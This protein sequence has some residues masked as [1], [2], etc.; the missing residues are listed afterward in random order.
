MKAYKLI[1]NLGGWLVFLIAAVVYIITA[2]PTA[3]FWDCGEYIAT[4]YKLQVGH[5]PGAPTFQL[6]GRFFSMFAFGN[7]ENV[8]FMVNML[9]AISSALTITFLFWTITLLGKKFIIK[10]INEISLYDKIC[11]FGAGAVGALAYTFT[12]SFWFSAVEG[13]VYALSSLVTAITFWAALKWDENSDS[14][15]ANRWMLFIAYIVGL[16]IGIHLLNLLALPAIVYLVYFKKYKFSW[17]G[18]V[19]AGMLGLIMLGLILYIIIPGIVILA[20]RIEIFFVNSL[21]MPFNSG[22]IFYI[23]LLIGAL[24]WGMHYTMKK[25]K[26]IANL[27][28]KSIVLLLIGYSTYFMLIIRSNAETPID[29]N[30]PS[31]AVNLLAY[32]QREQYGDTPLFHGPYYSAPLSRSEQWGDRNPVYAKDEE[33]KKYVIIDERKGVKPVY[34][35]EFST[36]FPRM[37]SGNE[38]HHISGYENW[39]KIKGTMIPYNNGFQTEMIKKPT[40]TENLRFFFSYQVGHMYMRY[41]MW[42]FAGRQNDIQGHGNLIDG[43]WISGINFIDNRLGPQELFPENMKQNKGRNRYYMLPLLLGLAGLA[44]HMK[45]RPKDAF[46][47]MVLF[48]MTGLAIVVYL[49]QTPYQPRERDYA[50]AASFYAFAIWI[51]IGV[52][53]LNYVLRRYLKQGVASI[54]IAIFVSSL[55]APIILAAE[56]W[57]D[58]DRSNRYT[59]REIAKNYLD[60]CEPNAIL[61]TNGDNDTFPLWYVQEVEGYRTDVRVVNLSLLNTDWY[62]NSMKR[63]AY[64]GEPVPF[65]LQEHQYQSGSYDVVYLVE[66]DETAEPVVINDLFTLIH[67]EP[68]RLKIKNQGREFDYFPT[69]NFRLPVDSARVV[70]LGIVSPENAHLIVDNIDW[71]INRGAIYKNGIMLLDLLAHN[72]WERPIYFAITTGDD[73]YFGLQ[74]YFQLEGLAYRLVPIKTANRPGYTGRIHTEKVYNKMVHEFQWGNMEKPGI[75]L[76]ETNR[77]MSMNFRNNFARLAEQLMFEGDTVRAIESL[78]RAMELM[79]EENVPYSFFIIPLA[80]SYY[81]AKEFDKGDAIISRYIDIQ[82]ENMEFFFAFKGSKAKLVNDDKE[83]SLAITNRIMQVT[84]KFGRTELFE[85]SNN[86]FQ[87]YYQIWLGGR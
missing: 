31:N 4:S 80:E 84:E 35:K 74:E 76:D 50:F 44:F 43:N 79:P 2:E 58:H 64:D 48:L 67:N 83:Q 25:Q 59:A 8:A 19:G 7:T 14:P 60:S 26:V 33:N 71:R 17:K 32:L 34:E 27:V 52:L 55:A 57:D 5:P 68:Q 38:P 16:S 45:V 78:D 9:S 13:E 20:G 49:N 77:R 73:A 41:F 18:F 12:D 86:L 22:T 23:L 40:F 15:Q 56:N 21:G 72:N 85:R 28:L 53:G 24:A 46:V 42:N 54:L 36:I 81:T 11:I 47:V 87:Q 3:S 69:K 70:E 10:N 6:L 39:G 1:N 37:W 62:V 66:R 51:G 61:F 29:E 82:T 65:S 63:K 75:Y 30:N